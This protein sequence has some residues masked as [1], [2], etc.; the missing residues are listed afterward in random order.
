MIEL[1]RD[2]GGI[3]LVSKML[4]NL[5]MTLATPANPNFK[6]KIRIKGKEY[7]SASEMPAKIK[8]AYAR[9]VGETA[10]LRSGARLAQKL[11]AR[12]IINDKEFT[13]P[14]EMPVAER[15]IYQDTLAALLP[16]DIVLSTNDA[17]KLRR[18]RA[19]LTLFAISAFAIIVHLWL[20]GFFG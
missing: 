1:M 17:A 16:N 7:A 8:E 6:A 13:N 15:R 19:L 3:E 2:S 20:R 10:L 12:I 11:N 14:G 4:I 5:S 18:K 9:A